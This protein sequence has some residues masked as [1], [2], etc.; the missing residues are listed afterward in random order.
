MRMSWF[1]KLSMSFEENERIVAAAIKANG[2]T[3]TAPS[4]FLAIRE[5]LESGDLFRNEDGKL[6]SPDGNLNLDLFLT[7]KGQLISRFDADQYF[8]MTESEKMPEQ[9]PHFV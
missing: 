5:A 1:S 7:N 9:Q 8:G 6:Q 2:K 3:F 4:H